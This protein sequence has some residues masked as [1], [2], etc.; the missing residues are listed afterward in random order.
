MGKNKS[1]PMVLFFKSA[2]GGGSSGLGGSTPSPT[3]VASGVK[4]LLSG[5]PA[6]KTFDSYS[7]ER[8]ILIPASPFRFT[9]PGVDASL[10]KSIRSGDMVQLFAIGEDGNQIPA[11]TGII[12]ET[13]THV[14]PGRVEYVLTGRDMLGQLVD[15]A[16]VDAQNRVIQTKN[17]TLE[18][19]VKKIIAN[20]QIPPGIKTQQV[21]T[22]TLLF[23]TNPGETKINA[24]QRYLEFT[25]CLIWSLPNGQIK[26]GKPNFVQIPNPKNSLIVTS[27]AIGNNILDCRVRRNTH[28]AIRQIVVQLQSLSL[29]DAGSFTRFNADSDVKKITGMKGGRSVFEVFSYGQGIDS[30][31]FIKQVGNFSGSPS[32]LGEAK[33]LR[34]IARD[35]MK[36]LDVEITVRGHLNASGELYDVDQLYFVKIEDDDVEDV[37]YVYAVTHEL[38][39]EHGMT[40]KLRMCKKGTI[41]AASYQ[42]PEKPV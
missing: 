10:R 27:D 12:D 17:L 23:Q 31:N 30:V 39:L 21:P 1:A 9:A 36:V 41:V 42:L 29:V 13:D 38:T 34:E 18:N 4:A 24:L 8:N 6:I 35:N 40:T 19:V 28:T 25:N 20:T 14:A 37:L 15:N 16:A 22:A 33:A 11:A 3:S 2:Q 32:K 7:F 26:V 5:S